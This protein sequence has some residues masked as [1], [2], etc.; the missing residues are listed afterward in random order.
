MFNIFGWDL[1]VAQYSPNLF[2]YLH[3]FSQ[4]SFIFQI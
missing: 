1:G 2:K 4:E 3:K